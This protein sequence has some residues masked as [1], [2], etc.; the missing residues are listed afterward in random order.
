M[1]SS[2]S[3]K[4]RIA[5]IIFWLEAV[6]MATVLQQTLGQSFEA[7]KKQILSNQH[8]ILNLVSGLSKSALITEE[9]AELQPYI[10]QLMSGTDVTKLFLTNS[11]KTIVI[12][13]SLTDIGHQL[14]QL[15]E[16]QDHS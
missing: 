16:R 12:S 7:S 14:P 11:N 9:Y 2:L 10:I 8:T 5:I 6:M 4:Y 3:L 1:F 15:K 13:S